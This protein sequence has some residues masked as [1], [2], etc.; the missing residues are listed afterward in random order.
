MSQN[1]WE[2]VKAAIYLI[3]LRVKFWLLN[4]HIVS[5]Y[6]QEAKHY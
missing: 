4:D 5:M 3:L 6:G 1:N 2:C